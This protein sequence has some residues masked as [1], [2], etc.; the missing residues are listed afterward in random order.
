MDQSRRRTVRATPPASAATRSLGSSRGGCS[1]PSIPWRRAARLA[2]AC[3]HS[4]SSSASPARGRPPARTALPDIYPSLFEDL[5][6]VAAKRR[7]I[8]RIIYLH[9]AATASS[10][11][12]HSR[13]T[14]RRRGHRRRDPR[15]AASAARAD[16]LT[17]ER[18]SGA[19]V[20]RRAVAAR[21][22]QRPSCSCCC[23]TARLRCCT[24]VR[25]AR[26]RQRVRRATRPG[27]RS[28]GDPLTA[29]G[30]GVTRR[31]A[32]RGLRGGAR[33]ATRPGR[34]I[35]PRRLVLQ[36]WPP[37]CRTTVD[38]RCGGR[39]RRTAHSTRA[40]AGT[41]ESVQRLRR[42]QFCRDWSAWCMPGIPPS[43]DCRS[44]SCVRL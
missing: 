2:S 12:S 7:P 41:V 25:E 35:V 19:S 21:A 38:P 29:A 40:G 18:S 43:V 8:K 34:R 22:R 28:P 17:R 30:A 1:A 11:R 5:A 26:G 31:V 14:D 3:Q 36:V 13:C 15:R 9:E 37:R 20:L 42:P 6:D 24:T 23:R 32:A 10:A 44:A 39:R 33:R 4:S 27:R 16:R